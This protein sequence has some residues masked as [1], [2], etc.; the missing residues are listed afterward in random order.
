VVLQ[1]ASC[2]RRLQSPRHSLRC[3]G[4]PRVDFLF[5][6]EVLE[7]RL[8]DIHQLLNNL[9]GEAQRQFVQLRDWRAGITADVEAFVGRGIAADLF[10]KAVIPD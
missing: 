2:A 1:L 5:L 4:K 10:F 9:P 3:H 8:T 7:R 6:S